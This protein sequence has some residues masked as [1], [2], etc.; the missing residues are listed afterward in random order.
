MSERKALVTL[1]VGDAF[2]RRW[3]EICKKNWQLYADRHGYDLICLEEVL[4]H[5]ERARRRSPAWQKCLILSQPF[6]LNYDRLVWVDLDILIHPLAPDICA[7][8]PIDKIGAVDEYS[9]P[10]RA[11]HRQM[12]VKNYATWRQQGV[13]F[14]PNETAQQYYTVFGLAHGYDQVVQTG[15][16]VLSPRHHRE[17]LESVYHQYE[18]KGP[19]WNYEMR[20]LSYE[21]LRTDCAHWLDPRFNYIWGIYEALHFPFLTDAGQHPRLRECLDQAR[22]QT[23]FLH[24][25]GSTNLMATAA[26]REPG[27]PTR[28]LA[29]AYT[30]TGNDPTSTPI[31]LFLF[32]RPERTATVFETIRQA[33]PST[34]LLIADGPRAD[35]ARDIETCA[36]TRAVV[37]RIDW[38]CDVRTNFANTN[39]GLKARFD[40][41]MHWVFAQA[42]EAIILED[43][44]VPEPSFFRFCAEMLARY[45]D[46][47]RVLSISGNNFQFGQQRGE[48]SYYF[49]RHP[50]IWGWATWRRAWVHYDPGMSAW[51]QA[52]DAGWLASIVG[53]R[54]AVQYWSHIFELNHRTQEHWDYAWNFSCW[55]NAGMHV[56]PNV[57]LVSNHG[58]GRDASHTTNTNSKFAY[59]LTQPMIFP[60]VHPTTIAVDAEADAFTEDVLYSGTL[61]QLFARVRARRA[62]S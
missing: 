10:T 18:D 59:L 45:R 29:R 60:L 26:A 16:M 50:H 52:R 17:L 55:S 27:E 28:S 8:V 6:S 5:S 3:S 4:D 37:A 19:A 53:D 31:A 20:P 61:K 9:I 35:H 46:D 15:A 12:L 14:I 2:R 62:N 38:P 23:Y 25:A 36:A 11:L 54:H 33:R 51:P 24:F 13:A 44:C 57:N 21:I 41:G 42:E 30:S 49:S 48:A 32:N 1:A 40:S 7:G 39:L 58:F 56:L 34:L 43:D 47:E 22:Q